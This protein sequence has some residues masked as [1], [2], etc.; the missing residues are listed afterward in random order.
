MLLLLVIGALPAGVCLARSQALSQSVNALTSVI[1]NSI[2]C[3]R[4]RRGGSDRDAKTHANEPADRQA[5]M[6]KHP[7]NF[8]IAAFANNHAIPVVCAFATLIF[9][10]LEARHTIIQFNTRKLTRSCSTVKPPRILTAYSRSTSKRGCIS[11]LASSPL[12]VN[13]NKPLVL[14]S[15]RP[16][17]SSANSSTSANARIP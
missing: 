4:L 5:E 11:R 6:L 13:T 10:H 7:A 2:H 3:P 14:Q 16:T 12:V 1:G 9:Q 8:A 15:R 17:G